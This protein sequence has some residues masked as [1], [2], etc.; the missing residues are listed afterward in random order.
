MLLCF[1]SAERP[2]EANVEECH[3]ISGY[4]RRDGFKPATSFSPSDMRW[5]DFAQSAKNRTICRGSVQFEQ[6]VRFIIPRMAKVFRAS[7]LF[8]WTLLLFRTHE[9]RCETRSRDEVN[10]NGLSFAI[11]P[12]SESDARW[13]GNRR[14]W[15]LMLSF[16][17]SGD[18]CSSTGDTTIHSNKPIFSFV[19]QLTL[20][21]S[22]N[23]F[24]AKFRFTC[25][26]QYAES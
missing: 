25:R 11:E 2:K 24:I 9:L 13:T 22:S 5:C 8:L 20:S 21:L 3:G 26:Y 15:M 7:L 10:M 6:I 19:H 1:T 4:G 16:N 17:W 18:V 12:E 23:W 14:L